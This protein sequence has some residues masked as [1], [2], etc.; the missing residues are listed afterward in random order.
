MCDG[1]PQA[2]GVGLRQVAWLDLRNWTCRKNFGIRR[3]HGRWRYWVARDGGT[4]PG[5]GRRSPMGS[6]HRGRPACDEPEGGTL[7]SPKSPMA[8]ASKSRG[9]DAIATLSQPRYKSEPRRYSRDYIAPHPAFGLYRF[10]I[11]LIEPDV[12]GNGT[13]NVDCKITARKAWLLVVRSRSP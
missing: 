6:S 3:S 1:P 8:L 13:R 11:D 12:R 4:D 2:N 5:R 9:F 10:P 7:R